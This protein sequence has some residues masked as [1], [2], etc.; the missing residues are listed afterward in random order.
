MNKPKNEVLTLLAGLTML[1]VGLY[2]LSQKVYVYSGFFSGFGIGG[3]R[4][5][6]GLIMVPL[7]AGILWL[8]AS[9]GNI[10]A[11]ILT[12]VGA[13]IILASIILSVEFHLR[14]MTLYD[15]IILMILI[16]GGAGL[17]IRVLLRDRGKDE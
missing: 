8:F 12:A 7:I 13:I 1:V 15:W 9:G 17:V 11:K 10:F 2:I 3:M 6:G 5:S 16:F 14:F 4:V